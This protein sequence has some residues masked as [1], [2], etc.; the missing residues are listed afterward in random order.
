[1]PRHQNIFMFFIKS[2]F[3][4]SFFYSLLR[5][6]GNFILLC[7]HGLGLQW[8]HVPTADIGVYGS[9]DR[10]PPGPRVAVFLKRINFYYS[11]LFCQMEEIDVNSLSSFNAQKT[12]SNGLD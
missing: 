8:H 1:M 4:C 3:C 10:I 7:R 2:Y 5:G 6:E 12:E 11:L 9:W